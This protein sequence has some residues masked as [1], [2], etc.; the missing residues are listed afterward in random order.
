MRGEPEM[1]KAAGGHLTSSAGLMGFIQLPTALTV[2]RAFDYY[3]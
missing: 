2:Y 1:G 3:A